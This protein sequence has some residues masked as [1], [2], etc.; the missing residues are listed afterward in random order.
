MIGYVLIGLRTLFSWYVMECKLL[1]GV[2]WVKEREKSSNLK[3]IQKV[4]C[5]EALAKA[6]NHYT[7]QMSLANVILCVK[8]PNAVI[9]ARYPNDLIWLVR[10]TY[11]Y[12]AIWLVQDTNIIIFLIIVIITQKKFLITNNTPLRRRLHFDY[13]CT[14]TLHILNKVGLNGKQKWQFLSD[15]KR[16]YFIYSSRLLSC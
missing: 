14:T 7:Y 3:M 9:G 15:L 4:K 16:C 13:I 12:A 6:S 2:L 10:D 1:A 11:P 5:D 8:P